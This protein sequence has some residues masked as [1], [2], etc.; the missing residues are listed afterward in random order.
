[1]KNKVFA[2]K[3]EVNCDLMREDR[4]NSGLAQ[5]I[6]GEVLGLDAS[7]IS[8]WESSKRTPKIASLV[9]FAELMGKNPERYVEGEASMQ[10]RFFLARTRA[11]RDYARN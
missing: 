4:I 2:N 6:V 1:M 8:A 10:L 5:D 3:H 7:A 11:A 9:S